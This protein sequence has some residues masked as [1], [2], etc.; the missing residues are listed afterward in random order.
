M[1]RYFLNVSTNNFFPSPPPFSSD[2]KHSG[3]FIILA[4][5]RARQRIVVSIFLQQEFIPF[6]PLIGLKYYDHTCVVAFYPNIP[7]FSIRCSFSASLSFTS[8]FPPT[9]STGGKNVAAFLL[10]SWASP[11]FFTTSSYRSTFPASSCRTAGYS[12]VFYQHILRFVHWYV[13]I[14]R[15]EIILA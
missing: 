3:T 14:S 6:S 12:V 2:V 1:G 9:L 15:S 4:Y 7:Y 13:I 11:V 8:V 5:S 10:S